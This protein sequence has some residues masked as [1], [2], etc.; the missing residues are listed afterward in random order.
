MDQYEFVEVGPT[1]YDSG[2]PCM[3][4]YDFFRKGSNGERR[5]RE[6]DVP[7]SPPNNAMAMLMY[8]VSHHDCI[9]LS[10]TRIGPKFARRDS[11]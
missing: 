2:N 10:I 9:D 7:K 6:L 1:L 3:P 8:F 11:I 5:A 4:R